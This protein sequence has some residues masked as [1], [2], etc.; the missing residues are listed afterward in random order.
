MADSITSVKVEEEDVDMMYDIASTNLKGNA[1]K[2]ILENGRKYYKV[3]CLVYKCI[4]CGLVG[5]IWV[6]RNMG[7]V[8]EV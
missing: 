8:S 3:F 6:L 5:A 2:H 4:N 1:W 7:C